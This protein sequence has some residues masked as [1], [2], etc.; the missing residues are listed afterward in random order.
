[1]V[2]FQKEHPVPG[3]LT[4]IYC[5]V[6]YL[7]YFTR[8][9]LRDGTATPSTWYGTWNASGFGLDLKTQYRAF[10]ESRPVTAATKSKIVLLTTTSHKIINMNNDKHSTK[11]WSKKT[12]L[13]LQMIHLMTRRRWFLPIFFLLVFSMCFTDFFHVS[14]FFPSKLPDVSS[15]DESFVGTPASFNLKIW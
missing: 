2:S 6:W 11:S 8:S 5:T 4:Y 3:Y 15:S 7:G 9:R 13:S 10:K 14:S 12:S 1:M